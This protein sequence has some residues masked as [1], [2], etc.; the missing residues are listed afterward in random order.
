MLNAFEDTEQSNVES[1]LLA[2][3]QAKSGGFSKLPDTY[4]DIL[5]SFYSLS[6]MSLAGK[7]PELDPCLAIRKTKVIKPCSIKTHS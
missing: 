7:L 1:F 6:W 2:H 3:C 5:H 4:P